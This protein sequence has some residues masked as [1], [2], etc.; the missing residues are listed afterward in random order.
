MADMQAKEG[1]EVGDI[2]WQENWVERNELADL[3]KAL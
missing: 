1:R 3:P 2:E